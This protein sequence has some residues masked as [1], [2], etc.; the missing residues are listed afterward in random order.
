MFDLT[1]GDILFLLNVHRMKIYL[2]YSNF[3]CFL[4]QIIQMWECI[5]LNLVEQQLEFNLRNY[6]AATR[7]ID[8]P[9]Y[10]FRS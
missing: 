5:K 2:S 9:G 4:S 6:A 8:L 1:S 10:L 7:C 3:L